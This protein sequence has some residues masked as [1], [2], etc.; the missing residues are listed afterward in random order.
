MS[1]K[2][3]VTVKPYNMPLYLL[4]IFCS[5]CLIGSLH[6]Q[7]EVDTEDLAS[8]QAE[9]SLSEYNIEPEFF[10]GPLPFEA[11]RKTDMSPVDVETDN[12]INKIS[13]EKNVDNVLGENESKAVFDVNNREG[14]GN[15]GHHEATI[16]NHIGPIN[17][18]KKNPEKND[19]DKLS[20]NHKKSSVENAP[21][22][23]LKQAIEPV[24]RTDDFVQ[25]KEI[26][27][28]KITSVKDVIKLKTQ[29]VIKNVLSHTNKRQKASDFSLLNKIVEPGTSTRL[30]WATNHN[31][32]GLKQ[33][34]PVL[35]VNGAFQGPTLCLTAAIHGD[36]LNG[37][38]IVRRVMYDIDPEELSG[39][40]IGVPIVNLQGFQRLS[41]YLPDRRDLNRYFPGLV[42]GSLAARIAYSF[43]SEVIQHC[44]Y[45]IDIHTGSLRRNNLAQLRADLTIDKVKSFTELF[46]DI[47]VVHS[48]GA[49]G[50]LRLAAVNH[51]GIPA[52]TLEV[53]ESMQIQD[54]KIKEGVK[55]IRSVLD[56][57]QMYDSLLVWG[58]A[59]PVYLKS[60]WLRSP[61]GG[62]FYSDVYLGDNIWKGDPLGRVID[63]ITNKMTKILAPFDGKVIGMANDQVLMPGYAIYNIGIH[64]DTPAQMTIKGVDHEN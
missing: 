3:L 28:N 44:D 52:V 40:L 16:V 26:P 17:S 11:S 19:N 9:D 23:D 51:Q 2:G 31:I 57:L 6:S 30:G 27:D 63:P 14:V 37:I 45:L 54:L 18:E 34:T 47:I 10:I 4:Y 58:D 60:Q 50:M 61:K 21:N 43:F 1:R 12:D 25:A 5:L 35:V 48:T 41:R 49:L 38:E 7:A 64:T 39:R 53:G 62:I 55:S 32:S 22:I 29:S 33:P 13:N 46:D 36:E 20:L 42:S 8:E 24:E 15:S 59:K 56:R